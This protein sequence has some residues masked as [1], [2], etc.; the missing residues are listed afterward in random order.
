M[1]MVWEVDT[2][3]ICRHGLPGTLERGL[4]VAF[5]V[6]P[7]RPGWWVQDRPGHWH[8]RTSLV[9]FQLESQAGLW[10]CVETYGTL[11]VSAGQMLRLASAF[12][13]PA[14][15]A[16]LYGKN[17][18]HSCLCQNGGSCDPILGQC[19][20]PEGWTGL[21]CESGELSGLGG[22][23][24]SGQEAGLWRGQHARGVWSVFPS[25]QGE[26]RL[27]WCLLDKALVQKVRPSSLPTL[28]QSAFLDIMGLVVSST[29]VA[30]TGA[31]VTGLL[32]TAAAQ[33]AG[34]GT[35]VRSVSGVWE[36]GRFCQG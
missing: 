20:C 26:G 14:C 15:P 28:S 31:H 16:G 1:Y 13:A 27:G 4:T 3:L 36:A 2:V 8:H 32:A 22:R 24:P 25:T 30:L 23:R 19:V 11:K 18:Q 21:A 29:A 17:C 7:L 5:T 35:S 10:G 12:R 34:L 6:M 9:R 33:L